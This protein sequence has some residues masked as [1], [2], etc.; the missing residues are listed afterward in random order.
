MMIGAFLTQLQAS[1]LVCM[2]LQEHRLTKLSSHWCKLKLLPFQ[3]RLLLD[4]LLKQ[5]LKLLLLLR[6]A[7]VETLIRDVDYN[8][9]NYQLLPPNELH[10]NPTKIIGSAS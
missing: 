6:V 8:F 2:F 3:Q 9:L 10:Q 7:S 5:D 4:I 1:M